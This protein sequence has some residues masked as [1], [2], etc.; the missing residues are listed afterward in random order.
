MKFLAT[1]LSTCLLVNSLSA[2][3]QTESSFSKEVTLTKSLNF[4][5]SLPKG[6]DEDSE[7]KWPLVV[8]LHGA[9]ERGDELQKVAAWGPP[10]MVAEGREFPFILISPQCP[11]D[12]WWALEP[13]MELIE[14]AEETYRVDAD[15]IILTGLSMGGYGT[16]HFASF[17]PNKFAAI[18]PICGDGTPYLVRSITHLPI[19]TFHGAADTVVPVGGTDRLVAE[20]KKRGNENVKYDRYEGVGH[21]SWSQAYAT[22][23]LFPWMMEQRRGAKPEAA[24]E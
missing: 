3:E 23:G 24:P 2:G 18:V 4:L 14:H 16:W 12:S 20:L 17:N 7:K 15:Q 1:V 21:N 13:V 5:V 9:G 8:F 11:A 19:W 6:Y 22:E 10:K